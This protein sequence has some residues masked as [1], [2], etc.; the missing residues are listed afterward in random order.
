[1]DKH[2][3]KTAIKKNKNKIRIDQKI[4]KMNNHNKKD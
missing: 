1:M 2:N 3:K 4:K